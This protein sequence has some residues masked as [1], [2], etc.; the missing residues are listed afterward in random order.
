MVKHQRPSHFWTPYWY[1]S[2][3]CPTYILFQCFN[4]TLT[5]VL[6]CSSMIWEFAMEVK[7]LKWRKSPA[8]RHRKHVCGSHS[9]WVLLSLFSL[10]YESVLWTFYAYPQRIMVADYTINRERYSKKTIWNAIDDQLDAIR[11]K[12]SRERY[13]YVNLILSHVLLYFAFD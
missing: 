13:A 1:V 9:W 6:Y 10:Q 8:C 3:S 5:F 11:P 2:V 4:L 12:S 7:L